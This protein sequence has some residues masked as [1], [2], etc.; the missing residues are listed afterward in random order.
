VSSSV[1]AFEDQDLDRVVELSLAAW[2]PVFE[3]FRRVLGQRLYY[4]AYP[5]WRESQARTVRSVC[6][7]EETDVWVAI[8]DDVPAGFVASRIDLASDP[9]AGEIEMIA[10]D[11]AH[12]RSGIATQLLDHAINQLHLAGAYLVAIASG[13]DSGHAPA[14]KL[15]EKAGFQ[16]LPLVRYYRRP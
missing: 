8:V 3:S 10:V 1:R 6:S 15:Y 5:D 7:S 11:P 2:A 16:A 9:L 4:L 13:G 14:R 12:Q